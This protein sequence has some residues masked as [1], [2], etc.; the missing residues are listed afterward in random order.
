MQDLEQELN[1]FRTVVD[2]LSIEIHAHPAVNLA[3]VHN[4]VPLITSIEIVNLSDAD[5]VDVRASVQLFGSGEQL[6]TQRVDVHDGPLRVGENIVWSN[7]SS[8]VPPVPHL[9]ALNE[10]HPATISV[11][12]SRLWGAD[13][14]L[15]APIRV[16]AHNEWFNAPVFYDSLAAFVQPNTRA[17]SSVLDTA[18]NLLGSATGDP[19][20]GGYQKGPERAAQIAA[21][22][23]EALRHQQIRYIDPP[24]SFEDTGQKIRTTAQVLD[25]RFGTC[26]DLA[27]TYAACLEAVGLRPVLWLTDGHAFAGFLRDESQL[28]HSTIT[29]PNALI[30]VVESGRVV[31][32]EAMYY[33][34]SASGSFKNAVAVAKRH[35]ANRDRLRGVVAISSARKDGIRPLPSLDEVVAA[36]AEASSPLPS[37]A[38]LGLPAEL[39]DAQDTSDLVLDT[40]DTAPPRVQ[41]WKRSLLDLS[42][43]NRLL[44]LKPTREVIDLHVPTSGLALLDDFVHG[45]HSIELMPHDE[46]S[47]IHELQGARRAQD[48][49][50]ATVLDYLRDQKRIHAVVTKDTY[51]VRLKHLQRTAH[52][53]FEETGNANLYLTFG[54]LIHTTSSGN[55]ARAPLFLLP[56]KVVGGSGRSQFKI[57]VDT[58]AVSTPNYCLVEWLRI[59]HNATIPAL[60]NPP[61]DDNG[62]DIDE[63]LKQIRSALVEHNLDF[64]I[65][66]TASVAIC[67][68]GTFGIWKDL[69]DSWDILEQS[70]IVRHLTH[71]AGES[72]RDARRPDG[73]AI[74]SV[75]LHELDV[76]VPIP[77][78]GSQLRAVALA[79]DGHTFVLEGPPGTGKSQTITNLIAHTLAQGKSVLFVAEKQ[80]A[81][82][83]VK[84]RLDKVG[85]TKFTLDLHG[86]NQSANAIRSQLKHAIENSATYN[87]RTW[88]AKLAD[89]RSRHVPLDDY[90]VKVHQQNGVDHSLWSAYDTMLSLGDG[91]IAPI[92]ATYVSNPT[93]PVADITGALQQFERAARSVTISRDN[94]WT[95]AGTID[96]HATDDQFRAVASRLAAA[97]DTVHQSNTMRYITEQL[98]NPE[99]I[100]ILLPQARRQVGRPIPEADI[101]TATHSA[102][103]GASKHALL[104]EISLLQQQCGPLTSVFTPSFID[105]G[106]TESLA[107]AAEEAGK[108]LFGKKKRTEQFIRDMA[109]GLLPGVQLDP[110]TALPLLRS[111]PG[112]REL[113]ANTVRHMHELLTQ[114][115]PPMW[116]PFSPDAIGHLQSSF[117][118]IEQSAQFLQA[119]PQLWQTLTAAGPLSPQDIAVL[120]DLSQAWR[121]WRQILGA[122]DVEVDRWRNGI[123]WLD[124]CLRDSRSW[125]D[126]IQT[127]GSAPIRQ[128]SSMTG[129]LDPLRTAGLHDLVEE[130][131]TGV[132]PAGQAEIAFMRGVAVTSHSERRRKHGLTQFDRAIK[133]GE[134]EDFANA[135]AAGRA[136]QVTALPAA[137]LER[138]SFHAGSLTGE[139]GNL[140][141]LLDAKRGGTSFRQLMS[142][143]GN[144]ILEATPCFFVSPTSLAQ[145]VPPGSV[146]FDL[147]VFDEASQVTVPQAIGA[148]GRGRSAVIVGDSQQM[149]PTAIGVVNTNDGDEYTEDDEV[150]PEDLDSILTEAVESGVPRLWLSWH[151]RSQDES[152]IAF[153]NEKYYEGRLASLP[154]PGGDDTAGVEWRRVDGHFNRE[155]KDRIRTN[156]VEAEAIVAEIR[157]RLSDAHLADQSIGVVTFN[158]QQQTLVRDLLEASG[159]PLILDQLRDDRDD[160]I[161][162][163]NLENV[164][165]DERDVILFSAAF[166]KKPDDPKLPLNFGPLTNSGGEKRFNVAVTRARRKVVIFSSFDPM[167]IDLSRTRSVGLAHLRGYL[168]MAAQNSR[169]DD[170]RPAHSRGASDAVQEHLVRSI[171]ENG[172]EVEANYGLSEFVLDVVVREPGSER[173]QVAVML[174]GPQWAQRPTVADRDLTPQLLESMMHWGSSVRVWLPDWIDNPDGVMTQIADAVSRSKERQAARRA[175][176][177]A[178]AE[179]QAAA[180]AA[181]GSVVD[182]AIESLDEFAPDSDMWIKPAATPAESEPLRV[183]SLTVEEPV[184]T[185]AE[186]RNWHG[187][188]IE[189]IEAPTSNL[190]VREDLDRVHSPAV[191]NTITRA[192]QETVE[193]EGPISLDR[194]ARNVAKRFGFDR[195]A[196]GRREF[197]LQTVPDGLIERSEDLGDFAWPRELDRATW[198]GFRRTHSELTRALTDVAPEEIINAMMSVCA[199]TGQPDYDTL[200]RK[201]LTIFNQKRLTGP[202]R[203]RLEA[204]IDLGVRR[205]RL[206]NSG[207]EY[208]TGH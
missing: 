143:Y 201:T 174:D 110:E 54:A 95:I 126:A 194:L 182:D 1:P 100:D 171:R 145:F 11:T 104:G 205:G 169:T 129:Y 61:L 155:T 4:G 114:F 91:P 56:I 187:R 133:N 157:S 168:E 73:S 154:S 22:I 60:Q 150:I 191:R 84:K 83:V 190:G 202:T 139:V 37:Q 120:D 41:K 44:N 50:D 62:I 3:L 76:P 20:L 55:E 158:A 94:P 2:G 196:A 189:Y 46:L 151:Y 67:Q 21:G 86:K 172:Y 135:S 23:Y 43:R 153:S 160:G 53:M 26:I 75:P 113:T 128:W 176:I 208:R 90:P 123:H 5:I 107:V 68:F 18:S 36:K 24:A 132:I 98:P 167:D 49:D 31:P 184:L 175:Q 161:F 148:L 6:S 27:V 29:E 118:Y 207:G 170:A 180:I 64:R 92:P 93:V 97:L 71:S 10:S 198:R 159:D 81:L 65:D 173:W 72:F 34:T 204:V 199:Q 186:P 78:D 45:G 147:V 74:E 130:L 8:I 125:L 149:P 193:I 162:V 59:K 101:L 51:P 117:D 87:S 183:A 82:D 85:L 35:F 38:D 42:T 197:V 166:S 14:H 80:A 178:A 116:N 39:L 79:A 33:D 66:E 57:T 12:V 200:L 122:R 48:I 146:T 32:V 28:A 105:S 185:I 7:Y 103:W 119:Q 108:G 111:V 138:R 192:V 25:E 88:A 177:D 181:A 13:I 9:R 16:L 15:N 124:A 164:Q 63:A 137:L 136:E 141:R 52:T 121:S 30:N 206:I 19:S 112:A 144:Y 134:I 58:A 47:S 140:R 179:A 89:V 96:Q 109:P 131:L 127:D 195:V 142:R 99:T 203:E 40:N 156:I 70:P 17:V 102:Q 69:T 115:A 152:L 188:N 163:K 77:A 106:D 165:G